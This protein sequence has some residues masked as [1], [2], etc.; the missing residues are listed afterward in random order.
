MRAVLSLLGLLSA[1]AAQT[2]PALNTSDITIV[3]V[4]HSGNGC[5]QGTVGT[6][7]S[8]DRTTITLSFD[9]VQ[10]WAGPGYTS[11]DASKNC[12]VQLEMKYPPGWQFAITKSRWH[13]YFQLP[14]GIRAGFYTSFE[15]SSQDTQVANVPTA[16]L[17]GTDTVTEQ[18]FNAEGAVDRELGSMCTPRSY[19]AGVS[20][21]LLVRDRWSLTRMRSDAYTRDEGWMDDLPLTQQV[22]L[23]WQACKA[24]SQCF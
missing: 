15:I 21:R 11:R 24:C 3:K 8:P 17:N 13:G 2:Q 16:T 6:S 12:Q 7:F 23:R 4:A 1:A 10:L 22:E 18:L 19:T 9:A 14:D 5:P 20:D